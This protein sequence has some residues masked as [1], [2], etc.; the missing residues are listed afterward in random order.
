MKL[1]I[2]AVTTLLY[3]GPVLIVRE[4]AGDCRVSCKN[5]DSTER[6]TRKEQ[7]KFVDASQE[8]ADNSSNDGNERAMESYAMTLFK[9]L[10]KSAIGFFQ[11]D[12]ELECYKICQHGMCLG[13]HPAVLPRALKAVA[14]LAAHFRSKDRAVG[15]L[16]SL[17]RYTESVTHTMSVLEIDKE[18]NVELWKAF[19]ECLSSLRRIVADHNCTESRVWK[20]EEPKEVI[21][22]MLRSICVMCRANVN[23]DVLH[24]SAASLLVSCNL[25]GLFKNRLDFK[26][27]EGE[28]G[29]LFQAMA[30]FIGMKCTEGIFSNDSNERLADRWRTYEACKD[31]RW[32]SSGLYNISLEQLGSNCP[33]GNLIACNSACLSTILGIC[34]DRVTTS[35]FRAEPFEEK[36]L[37]QVARMGVLM[38]ARFRLGENDVPYAHFLDYVCAKTIMYYAETES[39]MGDKGHGNTLSRIINQVV[40]NSW[41][42]GSD[43]SLTQTIL[44]MTPK[45]KKESVQILGIISKYEVLARCILAK[46]EEDL[47][48]RGWMISSLGAF[49]SYL[50]KDA[51]IPDKYSKEHMNIVYTYWQFR[52]LLGD[53]VQLDGHGRSLEEALITTKTKVGKRRIEDIR[54]TLLILR[55]LENMNCLIDEGIASQQNY[56]K[57]RRT[58]LS[59]DP[60]SIHADPLQSCE[61]QYVSQVEK[62][63]EAWNQSISTLN[64]TINRFMSQDEIPSSLIANLTAVV[65]LHSPLHDQKFCFG[66]MNII[67][68]SYDN[69][70][71]HDRSS[72]IINKIC[73]KGG[74]SLAFERAK[75]HLVCSYGACDEGNLKAALF[76][77]ME[78]HKITSPHIC[79]SNSEEE[80]MDLWWPLM[81]EYL[82]ITSHL[83]FLFGV[84]GLYEEAMQSLREGLRMVCVVSIPMLRISLFA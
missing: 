41:S 74:P 2:S 24:S 72:Q 47:E 82:A 31:L 71:S 55:E 79:D 83:G 46:K 81:G 58:R 39:N 7:S 33:F 1:V 84:S 36:C 43:S 32:L 80:C 19:A 62:S 68:G 23:V 64:R 60:S 17:L 70:I 12:K 4:H 30:A 21:R 61:E 9:T 11:N 18:Q 77:A 14:A 37:D 56:L 53:A 76:H 8:V 59:E 45:R 22:T 40:K 5:K 35:I 3:S 54:L 34:H 25:L 75:S 26:D 29:M 28:K 20:Q 6:P 27:I 42:Q 13:I 57:S 65:E 66:V 73:S 48:T 16:C 63:H 67:H 52:D 51:F 38:K 78:A 15:I 44:Q 49:I 50:L 69:T 10:H